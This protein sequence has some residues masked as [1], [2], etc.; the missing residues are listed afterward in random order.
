MPG[1]AFCLAPTLRTPFH[2]RR[3]FWRT[4]IFPLVSLQ[5]IAVEDLTDLL[6]SLVITVMEPRCT[7]WLPES[8]PRPR[9]LPGKQVVVFRA[10][11]IL[12][13]EALQR[14]LRGLVLEGFR[15]EQLDRPALIRCHNGRRRS[16]GR[17][18]GLC[19]RP[20]SWRP[21]AAGRSPRLCTGLLSGGVI[22]RLGDK[23]PHPRR[24][25][26]GDAAGDL[27]GQG[28]LRPAQRR[29]DHPGE[30]DLG[31]LL[32]SS[33]FDGLQHQYWTYTSGR[34]AEGREL[35]APSGDDEH[36]GSMTDDRIGHGSP[37]GGTRVLADPGTSTRAAHISPRRNAATCTN[38]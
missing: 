4:A 34:V 9:L 5:C 37:C 38:S 13:D 31:G 14:L 33:S 24:D 36:A 11:P 19:S 26:T 12:D 15:D 2:H 7:R 25:L 10:C 18:Q 8:P 17:G 27:R 22:A 35:P 1:A 3:H 16:A 30:P 32:A 20:W 29:A 6:K 21:P 28:V 23:R